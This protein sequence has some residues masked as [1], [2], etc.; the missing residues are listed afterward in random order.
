MVVQVLS[1]EELKLDYVAKP[2]HWLFLVLPHYSMC[3]G[4][5]DLN[6]IYTKYSMCK[7]FTQTC[8]EFGMAQHNASINAATCPFITCRIY[9]PCCSE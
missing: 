9:K 5:R 8:V 7:T 2:L 1:L 4:L 3:T 6:V